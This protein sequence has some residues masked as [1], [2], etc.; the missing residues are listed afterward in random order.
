[1]ATFNPTDAKVRIAPMTAIAGIAPLQTHASWMDA[2]FNSE[3]LAIDRSLRPNNAIR[4]NSQMAKGAKNPIRPG[5]QLSLTE[6]AFNPVMHQLLLAN[7]QR[8]WANATSSGDARVWKMAPVETQNVAKKLALEKDRADGAPQLFLDGMVSQY[9]LTLAAGAWPSAVFDTAF[10]RYDY[11]DDPVQDAQTPTLASLRVRG[12]P[13]ATQWEGGT[14]IDLAFQVDA[15]VA[16][17]VKAVYS[18]GTPSFVGSTTFTVALDAW[19]RVVLTD[20]T[21]AGT[22]DEPIEIYV[23][24]GAL[25]VDDEFSF[26]FDR[27]EWVL[28]T[29]DYPAPF[30]T[31][32]SEILIDDEVFCV[33]NLQLTIADPIQIPPCLDSLFARTMRRRGFRSV[34]GNITRDYVSRDL[35]KKLERNVEF[36]L[37]VRLRNGELIPSGGDNEQWELLHYCPKGVFGGP[38][39]VIGGPDDGAEAIA[40]TAYEDP[41]ES[42]GDTDDCSLWL[43]TDQTEIELTS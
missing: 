39:K 19:T 7:I 31:H 28:D 35:Q 24:T 10:L 5:G 29:S 30:D 26:A 2:I 13:D 41:A 34:T 42:G 21:L 16:T 1:M 11:W 15:A 33:E 6:G 40:F 8:N 43:T 4:G 38:T 14:I 32:Y 18:N 22:E 17:T 9:A 20:G 12:L 25:S 37:N 23:P 3:S 36:S 27:S